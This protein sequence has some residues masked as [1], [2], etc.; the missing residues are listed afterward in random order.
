MHFSKVDQIY[1]KSPGDSIRTPA[2]LSF[3]VIAGVFFFIIIFTD[4]YFQEVDFDLR[5][6]QFTWMKVVVQKEVRQ[7]Q[8]GG[9]P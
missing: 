6:T 4:V 8:G 1:K 2:V 9:D 5:M 7:R 3:E